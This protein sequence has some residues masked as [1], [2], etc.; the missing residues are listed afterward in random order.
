MTAFEKARG[1]S[2]S[3]KIEAGTSSHTPTQRQSCTLQSVLWAKRQ[4]TFR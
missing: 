4:C 1:L 3:S 2:A